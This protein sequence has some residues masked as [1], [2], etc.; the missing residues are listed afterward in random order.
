LWKH[1]HKEAAKPITAMRAEDLTLAEDGG[2]EKV[3]KVVTVSEGV[4]KVACELSTTGGC[5]DVSDV[6]N[7]GD[8]EMVV[9]L[10]EKNRSASWLLVE[11]EDVVARL[12]WRL[13]RKRRDG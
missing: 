7:G 8:G 9:L 3:S 6:G 2:E 13:G 12:G 1:D 5:L 11:E 4:A 10:R